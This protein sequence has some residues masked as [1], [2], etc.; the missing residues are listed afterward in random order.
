[1][2][3]PY[4]FASNTPI[5]AIDLD[6]LEAIP[7]YTAKNIGV[8]KKWKSD[9]YHAGTLIHRAGT[10]QF[11]NYYRGAI[12]QYGLMNK[13]LDKAD[14]FSKTKFTGTFQS[15]YLFSTG[16]ASTK[17]AIKTTNDY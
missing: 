15:K 16:S 2:L 5:F 9:S 7:Y 6:G 12:K 14:F 17:G 8:M 11:E 3:T 1:M 13:Y 4:Q 10:P